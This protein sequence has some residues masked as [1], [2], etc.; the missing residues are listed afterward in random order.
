[1]YKLYL[2]AALVLT[3]T[4]CDTLTKKRLTGTYQYIGQK[5]R[6][7]SL[8]KFEL[9]GTKFVTNIFFGEQAMNYTVEDD[10]LYVHFPGI[11]YRFKVVS[12]D[13]LRNEGTMGFEGTYVRMK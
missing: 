4:G 13:T 3:V 7:H 12:S 9:T 2:C 5:D 8:N 6:F 10:Y 11:Q 1:M